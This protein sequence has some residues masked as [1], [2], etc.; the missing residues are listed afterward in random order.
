MSFRGPDPAADRR[1][2]DRREFLLASAAIAG[3]ARLRRTEA[4]LGRIG[5]QLYTVR[6][7]LFRDPEATL[8]RIARL[9]YREVEFT[10]YP[11]GPPSAVRAM[12]D[13]HG[14]TAPASH[15]SLDTLYGNWEAALEQAAGIGQR[16]LVV[17]FVPPP[18]RRTLDDWKRLAAAFNRAGEAAR[19]HE[20]RFCYHNHDYEFASL[21]G[22]IP[23]DVLLSATDRNLVE[24]ELDLYW[25]T[26]GGRDPLEYF[27]RWPG[28]FPLVHVKDMDATPR[29]WFTEAGRGTIDFRRIF[30][31]SAQAGIRHYFYEQDETQGD[32]FK[33][34]E[35][36][37]TYLRSL[38]F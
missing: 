2:T 14:L 33:S 16:Y 36:S 34:A 21:A 5:I 17:A 22:E 3:A 37:Y 1:L 29:R 27:S 31:R 32:V 38:T 15:V 7:E 11:P 23:Y 26:K 12:L 8:A 20:L 28:R 24:L 18:A 35:T 4:K 6:R 13:R 9:G 10:S 19:R 30:R 25:I